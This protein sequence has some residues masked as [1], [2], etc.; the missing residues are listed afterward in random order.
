M[1]IATCVLIAPGR[2]QSLIDERSLKTESIRLFVLDEADKLLE[3]SFQKQIKYVNHLFCLLS[4]LYLCGRHV[5]GLKCS[6]FSTV[7]L[8]DKSLC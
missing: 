5:H 3:E 8:S 4:L 7:S 2:I 6:C 1:T